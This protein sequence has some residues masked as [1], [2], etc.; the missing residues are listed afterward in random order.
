MANCQGCG[1][2]N[3]DQAL[4]CA[5]CGRILAVICPQ[6][7]TR[8]HQTASYCVHCGR[9]L[10]T[11][12]G[13]GPGRSGLDPITLMFAGPTGRIS[14]TPPRG[15]FL[16]LVLGGFFFFFLYLSQVLTGHPILAVLFGLMCGLIALWGGI[17]MALWYMVRS[18]RIPPRHA[19]PPLE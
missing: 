3:E 5:A 8:N 7:T 6:C 9:V 12:S 11:E 14:D 4:N 2:V 10:R 13:P 19:P 15:A 1:A 16:R 17:E 18:D